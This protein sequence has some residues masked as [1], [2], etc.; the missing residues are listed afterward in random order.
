MAHRNKQHGM[1]VH[2]K[3]TLCNGKF[4]FWAP[5]KVAKEASVNLDFDGDQTQ[6]CVGVEDF[7]MK[8]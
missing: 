7:H 3:V 1:L 8:K 6:L 5:C 4:S 2:K